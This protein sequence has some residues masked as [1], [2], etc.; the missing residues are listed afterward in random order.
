MGIENCDAARK[1]FDFQLSD[2]DWFARHPGERRFRAVIAGEFPFAIEPPPGHE[3]V[4]I[5][6]WVG[7][8]RLRGIGFVRRGTG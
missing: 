4:V 3:V 7:D 6:S 5:V 8:V 1:P 2:A